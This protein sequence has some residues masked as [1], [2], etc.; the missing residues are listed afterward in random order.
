V[1]ANLFGKVLKTYISSGGVEFVPGEAAVFDGIENVRDMIQQWYEDHLSANAAAGL[2]R[3]DEKAL[4]NMSLIEDVP[5]P[6]ALGHA[7]PAYKELEHNAT[8]NIPDGVQIYASDPVHD[9]KSTFVGR[10]CRITSPEQVRQLSI[11][12]ELSLMNTKGSCYNSTSARRQDYCSG[13]P[14]GHKRLEVRG[15]RPTASR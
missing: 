13:H 5:D 6:S 12:V 11:P 10:A 15:E 9:R 8:P 1:D 14:S 2:L 4:A 3:G 7:A